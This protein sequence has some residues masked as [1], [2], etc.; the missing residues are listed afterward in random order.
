MFRREEA[1]FHVIIDDPLQCHPP[2]SDS[3]RVT[4]P[5]GDYDLPLSSYYMCHGIT[6]HYEY[7]LYAMVCHCRSDHT[8]QAKEAKNHGFVDGNKRTA[9]VTARLFWLITA[10]LEFDPVD[11]IRTMEGGAAGR[12]GE[13]ELARWFRTCMT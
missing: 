3:Q 13:P 8:S 10:S 4:D 9:W 11:A 12:S 2:R 6:S 5:L 7:Y 1:D